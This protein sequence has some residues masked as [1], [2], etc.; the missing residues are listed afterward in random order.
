MQILESA[1]WPQKL[2]MYDLECAFSMP[3]SF[4][5]QT[6]NK[7]NHISLRTVPGTYKLFN[8]C[9]PLLLMKEDYQLNKTCGLFFSCFNRSL[10]IHIFTCPH[11]IACKVMNLWIFM[12]SCQTNS[13]VHVSSQPKEHL[14]EQKQGSPLPGHGCEGHRKQKPPVVA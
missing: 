14:C 13:S 3:Q 12:V 8:K 2:W 1:S 10:V 11:C 9:Q 5:L 4:I 6:G 7:Y